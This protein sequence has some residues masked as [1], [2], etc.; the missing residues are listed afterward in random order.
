[1]ENIVE[2]VYNKLYIKEEVLLMSQNGAV[3]TNEHLLS[4][5][6]NGLILRR[7]KQNIYFF[8]ISYY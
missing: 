4:R 5:Q 2:I 8:I 1:M 7:K 6:E 3:N